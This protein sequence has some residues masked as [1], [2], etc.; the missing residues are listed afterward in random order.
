MAAVEAKPD[1]TMRARKPKW[2][3]AQRTRSAKS[4]C[5]RSVLLK[6]AEAS[7]RTDDPMGR[8]LQGMRSIELLSAIGR[9]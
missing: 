1:E 4:R 7:E 8:Y 2:R 6:K 3:K 5:R 9:G